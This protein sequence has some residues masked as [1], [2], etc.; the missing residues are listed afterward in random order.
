MIRFFGGK[1]RTFLSSGTGK[2]SHRFHHDLLEINVH[3]NCES[4]KNRCN[5]E[6]TGDL[7]CSTVAD[8]DK[9]PILTNHLNALVEEI[10]SS[11]RTFVRL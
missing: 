3:C 5:S 8:K 9:F 7:S 11:V 2:L 10:C 4:T 1:K 6:P